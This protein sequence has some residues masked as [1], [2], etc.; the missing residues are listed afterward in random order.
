MLPDDATAMALSCVIPAS[1]GKTC[2]RAMINSSVSTDLPVLV[3]T[4]VYTCYRPRVPSSVLLT[5]TECGSGA[6]L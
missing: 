3:H 1:L 6:L 4:S 2:Y 5:N